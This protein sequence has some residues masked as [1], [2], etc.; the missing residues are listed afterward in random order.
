MNVRPAHQPAR[1][2]FEDI[3]RMIDA[4]VFDQRTDRVE[5]IEG[6]LRTMSP[7]GDEH[8]MLIQYLLEWSGDV[9]G[10]QYRFGCQQGVRLSKTQSMPEPDIFWLDVAHGRKRATPESVPLVIEVAASSLEY[11]LTVKQ[12]LY[13]MENIP[14]YW[15]VDVATESI[16]VHRQPLSE[17]EDQSRYG[18]VETFKIGQSIAP[19]CQPEAALDLNW[20]FHG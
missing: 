7:A 16:V 20:L 1:F 17:F 4:G 10:E 13:A 9:T 15:V 2:T 11:D 6:E 5:F 19:L 14:E 8:D 3:D 12:R 18:T